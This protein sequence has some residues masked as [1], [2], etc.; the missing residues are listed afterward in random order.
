MHKHKCLKCGYEWDSNKREPKCC[1]VCKSYFWNGDPR[2]KQ[3]EETG[4]AGNERRQKE[5]E[6]CE[7]VQAHVDE[8][9]EYPDAGEEIETD[10]NFDKEA[11]EKHLDSIPAKTPEEL[12]EE[13]TLN[14]PVD[15]L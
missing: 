10:S 4:E 14:T 2:E 13:G 9:G 5:R 12:E 8:T 7:S 1:P 3:E 6:E 11:Y 15:E